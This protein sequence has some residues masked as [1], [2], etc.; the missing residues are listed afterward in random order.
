MDSHSEKVWQC[1]FGIG[2]GT[3]RELHLI[4][5]KMECKVLSV[6]D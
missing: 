3:T 4:G 2:E 5:T 6:D 1:V